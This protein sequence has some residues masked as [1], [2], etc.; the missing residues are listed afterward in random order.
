MT[1][2]KT[3]IFLVVEPLKK[4]PPPSSLK[5]P[6]LLKTQLFLSMEK[7]RETTKKVLTPEPL[8]KSV[9]HK[10]VKLSKKTQKKNT[11]V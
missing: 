4:S 6:G 7:C 1:H 5:N 3:N 9:F 10:R 11:R 2:K 8:K